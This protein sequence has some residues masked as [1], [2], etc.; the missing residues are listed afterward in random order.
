MKLLVLPSVTGKEFKGPMNIMVTISHSFGLKWNTIWRI[1]TFP[2]KLG[3]NWWTSGLILGQTSSVSELMRRGTLNSLAFDP[4]TLN[5]LAFEIKG[6]EW[7][8]SNAKQ[9]CVWALS[10]SLS[11]PPPPL[12]LS[13]H[14]LSSFTLSLHSLSY[15]TT[16][17]YFPSLFYHATTIPQFQHPNK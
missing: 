5:S 16:Q 1:N 10:L 15:N 7:E 3:S 9:F 17:Y 12:I 4:P 8:S 2:L 6:G 13:L 11:P 14:T